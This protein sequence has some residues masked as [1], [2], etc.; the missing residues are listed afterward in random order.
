MIRFFDIILSLLGILVLSPLFFILMLIILLD[1][2]GNI[3]Y[4]Q[5][6]IG[7]NGIPFNLLKFRSMRPGSDKQGLLTVGSGD[8]RITKSGIWIR[9]F[10][11]D[12]LPQ[13][14]NVL[15]GNMSL[16]G[17]RPE[18]RKYV[19]LYTTEQKKV[20]DVLPG[21]TDLASIVYSNENELLDSQENPEDYYV[22]VIMPH[23][24]QLNMEFIQHRNIWNYFEIICKTIFRISKHPLQTK[25][26]V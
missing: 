14:I 13:L 1:S 18:V 4:R 15:I 6:R 16:V 10:K 21:I 5:E 12:E 25:N 19:E 8:L 3:F 22:K 17:P 26:P 2:P 11:L 7:K 20:L 9:R 24:I 23:K